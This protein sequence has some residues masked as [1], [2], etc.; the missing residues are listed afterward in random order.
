MREDTL[1]LIFRCCDPALSWDTHVPLALSTAC[2]LSAEAIARAFVTP[3]PVITARL[4]RGNAFMVKAG[5]A[6][7]A[8]HLV[9]L[10]TRVESVLLTIYLCFNEG[11]AA[12]AGEDV[13]RP[14]FC[15]KAIEL[16][17]GL[18]EL[19]PEEPEAHG[20]LALM[21]FHD[22]RRATRTDE[23]GDIVLLEDQNRSR[24]NRAQIAEGGLSLERALSGRPLGRFALEAAI[25]REHALAPTATET[26]WRR[27]AALYNQLAEL[28][29][30]PIV[31]LNR[32]VA[33]A[34]ADGFEAGLSLLRRIHFPGY[35]LLPAARADL[36]RRLGRRAEASSAYR[37]ALA[38]VDNEAERRFLKR[39]LVQAEG[40]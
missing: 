9:A 37:E 29:P 35:H 17:G 14:G 32:A 38:L 26:N 27:I 39:R 16:A 20:L 6:G 19:L 1:R 25:A 28:H 8:L 10:A 4:K 18:A 12:H 13:V 40:H 24:W 22:S 11:Y 5:T 2:G 30:T 34:M 15:A 23:A 31:E 3:I 7:S 36:L 33:I 21:L